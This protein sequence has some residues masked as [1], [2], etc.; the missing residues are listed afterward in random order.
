M[1]AC[2]RGLR[3]MLPPSPLTSEFVGMASYVPTTFHELPDDEG[4]SDGDEDITSSSHTS[5]GEEED[6]HGCPIH[7]SHGGGPVQLKLEHISGSRTSLP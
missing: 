4:E 3:G 6:Q 7:L 1:D 2:T 5:Q